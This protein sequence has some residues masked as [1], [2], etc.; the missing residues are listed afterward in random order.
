[1]KLYLRVCSNTIQASYDAWLVAMALQTKPPW[2]VIERRIWSSHITLPYRA[3]VQSGAQSKV[4]WYTSL[5]HSFRP[6]IAAT[7]WPFFYI[8]SGDIH[9]CNQLQQ[10]VRSIG[11]GAVVGEGFGFYSSLITAFNTLTALNSYQLRDIKTA[12][13]IRSLT[14]RFTCFSSFLKYT[15]FRRMMWKLWHL[16]SGW[17]TL[18]S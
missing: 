16:N 9:I 1:M 6:D 17:K 8:H 7:H 3:V 2:P 18:E 13:F 15:L 14:F 11:S 5:G 10:V 12:S 4:V